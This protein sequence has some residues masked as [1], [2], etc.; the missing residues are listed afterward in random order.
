MSHKRISVT[1]LWQHSNSPNTENN[2]KEKP[3]WS[4][5]GLCVR[6]G[7]CVFPVA[8][9]MSQ[10]AFIISHA[11][12]FP[13]ACTISSKDTFLTQGD[14]GRHSP[15]V[16]PE[17]HPWQHHHE[18]GRKVCLQQEEEDV[19]SQREVDVETIVPACKHSKRPTQTARK[20]WKIHQGQKCWH[21]MSTLAWRLGALIFLKNESNGKQIQWHINVSVHK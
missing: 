9:V 7:M 16:D 11:R 8:G 4:V 2:S 12:I 18:C 5:G 21:K 3:E 17:W 20:R 6:A 19:A 15:T 13:R 1:P 10:R 14:S